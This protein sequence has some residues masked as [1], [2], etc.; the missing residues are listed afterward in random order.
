MNFY[1]KTY[2][3]DEWMP[4]GEWFTSF[5]DLGRKIYAEQASGKGLK[6]ILLSVPVSDMVSLAMAIGFS[7]AAYASGQNRAE[8]V[9]LSALKVGQNVQMRAIWDQ[10]D[11]LVTP[12]PNFVGQLVGIEPGANPND[13][14]AL[15]FKFN[16]GLTV[17][18]DIVPSTSRPG[19]SSP[20]K[21]IRFFEVP[22]GVPH[23]SGDSNTSV[24]KI[25]ERKITRPDLKQDQIEAWF[26]RFE[27][28][29]HQICPTLAVF[30]PASDIR[31]Y[32]R[33]LFRDVE[34][35]DTVLNIDHDEILDV[36]RLDNLSN[37]QHPHFVN[38]I[39]QV[40]SFPEAGSAA[41]AALE[42]FPFVC[43][44]GNIAMASLAQKT[45]L[46]DKCLIAL[47]ETSKPNLQN[48]AIETFLETASQHKRLS[49]FET[50]IGWTPPLGVQ[51][52]AWV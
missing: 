2:I 45:V 44:D 35:H 5:I 18:R 3:Q 23:K 22:S 52:W 7:R 19:E 10:K 20:T 50:T 27:G 31:E 11:G 4:L 26:K 30:G 36:A 38:V 29:E 9:E 47:W 34:L 8:R 40:A 51:I 12:P 32:G 14:T 39:D 1:A 6:K 42:M 21:A 15:T 25:R 28:W 17:K 13:K 24:R 16:N 43:L 33:L 49:D 37:D 41:R 46:R 48:V